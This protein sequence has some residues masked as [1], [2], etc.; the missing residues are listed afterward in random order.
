MGRAPG[1]GT[2]MAHPLDRPVWSALA[3][4]QAKLGLG[5]GP[6]RRF[7]PDYGPFGAALDG[8]AESWAALQALA[9][10]GGLALVEAHP[11]PAPAGVVFAQEAALVQMAMGELAS[12]PAVEVEIV[13]LG[14][15]DAPEMRALAELTTPGPFSSRTHQLGDFVGVKH[16]G[17]LVAMAGERMKPEGFTEVSGV[18][19][20]PDWR[21]RGYAAALT[22]VVA[23][24][25]LARGETPFLHSYADNTG[26]IGLYETLGFR[27]R[28][29][30]T[31]RLLAPPS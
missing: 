24:R 9:R 12:G 19:T 16:E 15:A 17:R 8:S 30:M 10:D 27:L 28:S 4:R 5:E 3:T 14:E 20:H 21:G 18:C 6:A 31:M 13:A 25:I 22:R 23:G 2:A 1:Y 11:E 29:P 26:A 7:A